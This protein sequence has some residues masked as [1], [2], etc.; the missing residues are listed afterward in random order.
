MGLIKSLFPCIFRVIHALSLSWQLTP[1]LDKPFINRHLSPYIH[2][3]A[4]GVQH[5]G[6]SYLL[7]VD[8]KPKSFTNF[9]YGKKA[10]ALRLQLST[11]FYYLAPFCVKVKGDD[12]I[13]PNPPSLI[14]FT[15]QKYV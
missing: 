4:P 7:S 5:M 14:P 6:A 15:T 11:C 2:L 10:K 9:Y 13:Y 8:T 12:G 3:L 1:D